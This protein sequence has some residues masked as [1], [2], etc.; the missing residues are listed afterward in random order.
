L[1][2]AHPA[3]SGTQENVL[4]GALE[5]NLSP[6][7][8][9]AGLRHLIEVGTIERRQAFLCLSTHLANM[10]EED[11]NFWKQ[12]GALLGKDQLRPPV[13][14][15]L[16]LGLGMDAK[17]ARKKLL[18]LVRWKLVVQVSDNRFFLTDQISRLVEHARQASKDSSD[19]RF[20]A[21][22]Y[23]D[24]TG[25]GRNVAIE[26][27]EYFDRI[28]LTGIDSNARRGLYELVSN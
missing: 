18:R 23:R 19:G 28:K 11:E 6:D 3:E 16:S 15:E 22:E 5:I 14:Q 24:R 20:T 7:V 12:V 17:L 4:L 25:I 8:F 9:S 26:V 2:R 21:G 1:H 10:S 27:L 13:L